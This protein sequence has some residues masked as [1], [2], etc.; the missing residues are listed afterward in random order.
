MQVEFKTRLDPKPVLTV[1]AAVSLVKD[2][3][4]TAGEV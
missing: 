1:E 3:F 2:A 4:V